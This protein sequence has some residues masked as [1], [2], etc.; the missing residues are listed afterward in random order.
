[1]H[2]CCGSCH[3]LIA[4]YLDIGIEIL[5]PTQPEAD[6]MT[7][8]YLKQTYGDRMTFHGGIGLQYVLNRG[9]PQ[10]II[11]TVKHT[12]SVLGKGGGYILA[13]AH[14]LPE[15]VPAENVILML[16]TAKNMTYP[17]S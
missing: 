7:P 1:M 12:A 2:H 9:T 16:E 13:A 5:N 3:S 14:S 17:L 15:D 4:D 6:G 11:D 10:E 8:E